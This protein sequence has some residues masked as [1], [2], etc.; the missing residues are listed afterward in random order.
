[1]AQITFTARDLPRLDH[2]LSELARRATETAPLMDLIGQAVVSDIDERFE[3][4]TAPDGGKWSPSLRARTEGGKT[5][6]KSARLRGSMTHNVLGQA[7]VEI[8][9]NVIYGRAHNQGATIRAKGGGRLRFKLPGGLGWRSVEE[10]V[11]PKREFL[12]V[13]KGGEAEIV[14]QG[15]DY[16]AGALV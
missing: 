14:A 2:I 9:T 10:V 1:M 13:S 3:T 16:L 4:E 6:T 11:L 15:E 7:E 5:L 8:G 12:G